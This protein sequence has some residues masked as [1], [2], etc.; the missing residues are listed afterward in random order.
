MQCPRVSRPLSTAGQRHDCN[1]GDRDPKNLQPSPVAVVWQVRATWAKYHCLYT[2]FGAL[3]A[4]VV[5]MTGVIPGTIPDTWRI[6]NARQML[7]V[8][9]IIFS[10]L[11]APLVGPSFTG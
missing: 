1:R 5:I 6:N 4:L 7:P 9:G 2:L 11:L 3:A 10:H 8:C